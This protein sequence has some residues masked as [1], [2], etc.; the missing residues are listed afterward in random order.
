LL[1]LTE[2]L[3]GRRNAVLA[4]AEVLAAAGRRNDAL[5]SLRGLSLEDFGRVLLDVADRFPALRAALPEMPAESI[6]RDWTGSA[7][8]D[9]LRQTVAFVRSMESAFVKLCGRPLEETTIL[10]Y[11]CGWGRILRVMYRYSPPETLYG[12]DPWESSLQICRDTRLLGNL[13][14]CDDVPRD[15]PFPGVTFDL[16][17]A[18]SV[19]T[20]LSEKTATAVLGAIRPRMRDDGLLVVTVRPA[21]YWQVQPFFPPGMDAPALRA[22]HAETGFA[23][24]PHN[25]A[26]IDGDVTFGDTSIS[27]DYVRRQWTEW[28]LAGHETNRVDPYQLILF[29][30][31]R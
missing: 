1:K 20:H 13:A 7:G 28:H 27:L 19:L 3:P 21:E 25:R 18:S 2:I 4:A 8:R 12:I 24:V 5:R 6:Q 26:P 16:V 22:R 17:Y 29:L 23:F 30:R 9:L 11:G 10:D 15:L 14:R 31:P